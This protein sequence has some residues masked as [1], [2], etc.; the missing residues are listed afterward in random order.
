MPFVDERTAEWSSLPWPADP[1][2]KRNLI[3]HSLGP[4]LINWAEGRLSED[5]FKSARGLVNPVTGKLWAFTP[6]QKRALILMLAYSPENG[7]PING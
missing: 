3:E 1:V 7:E 4:L 5:E 6:E 2:E